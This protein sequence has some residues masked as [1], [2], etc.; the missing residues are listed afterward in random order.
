MSFI[1]NIYLNI[2]DP[3]AT[4]KCCGQKGDVTNANS[5]VLTQLFRSFLLSS[6][7][8][9]Q[10]TK[11]K[12]ILFRSTIIQKSLS[13]CAYMQDAQNVEREKGAAEKKGKKK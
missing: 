6:K 8:K 11:A 7:M 12:R 5:T 1:Y 10:G 4:L 3:F 13:N 9:N 2:E